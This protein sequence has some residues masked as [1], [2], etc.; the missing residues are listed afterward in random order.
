M[1]QRSPISSIRWATSIKATQP[2]LSIDSYDQGI[3]STEVLQS[4]SRY[5]K[6]KGQQ[7]GF[8]F[9]PFALWAWKNNISGHKTYQ[10]RSSPERS[11]A[12]G[13]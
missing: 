7:M 8:Y 9:I 10:Y 1:W 3:Y 11:V 6:K 5:G 4:I 12:V 13:R 2:V